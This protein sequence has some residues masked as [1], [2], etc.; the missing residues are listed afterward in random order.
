MNGSRKCLVCLLVWGCCLS[1]AHSQNNRW[2]LG[3]WK[4]IGITPG[5]AY[6]TV[7]VR[8][9]IIKTEYKN[10]LA[11]IFIQEVMDNK[12]TRIVKELTGN[13]VNNEIKVTTGRTLYVKQ[14]PHGF[15]ADCNA[16]TMN[17]SWIT[18][19]NDSIIL[20][21]ETKL[22]GK[23][24]DGITTYYKRLAD[25]DTV[26][27]RKIVHLFASSLFEKNFNP[28]ITGMQYNGNEVQ[29]RPKTKPAMQTGTVIQQSGI[30]DPATRNPVP[31]A[32]KRNNPDL[33]TIQNQLG[34]KNKIIATYD[35][36]TAEIKIELFDNGE[37]DGDTVTV[38]HN[39]QRI[40]D[41]KELGLK[42]IIY[43]VMASARDRVHEFILVANNLGRIPPN[44][45]LMRITAGSK[46]YEVFAST[47]LEDNV[48]VIIIYSG[49]Q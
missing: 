13:F 10:R 7:F 41:R 8:T 14:P 15:W 20:T 42:P 29:A 48:S 26:T 25:F 21:Y 34:R 11:G 36:P 30:T 12:G 22:C 32:E 24:C 23:P 33:D 27:Q 5:S 17:S 4:G 1:A 43:T 6:N 37:I 9:M 44:T 46:T 3:E 40:I 49:E 2:I 19:A 38:Y 35:V 45:A 39:K 28:V 47:T 18:I 16:C 31:Y